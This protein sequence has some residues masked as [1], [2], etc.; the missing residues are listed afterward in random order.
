[1][2]VDSPT[3]DPKIVEMVS[4][5]VDK[6]NSEK[7]HQTLWHQDLRRTKGKNQ[8]FKGEVPVFKIL[9]RV[10]NVEKHLAIF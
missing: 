6:A 9:L 8:R 2:A 5:M 3:K 1:M 7:A 4:F 10:R